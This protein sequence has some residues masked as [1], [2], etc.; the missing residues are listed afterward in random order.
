MTLTKG[1]SCDFDYQKFVVFFKVEHYFG[2]ISWIAGSID[3]K[4]NRKAQDG[5][6]VWYVTLTFD[7]THDLDLGCFKVKFWNSC[8]SGIVFL[9]MWNWKESKLIGYWAICMTLPF[10]R[11]YDFYLGVSRS[12]VEIALSQES[13]GR[14]TWNEK[15]VS[16]QFMTMILTSVALALLTWGQFRPLGIVVVYISV[17]ASIWLPITKFVY[18]IIHDLLMLG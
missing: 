6:W 9:M 7:L 5:Y 8:T 10:H 14:L 15:D 2:H 3:E 13:D 11:T 17:C 12:E 1:H 18:M 16:P 4:Q